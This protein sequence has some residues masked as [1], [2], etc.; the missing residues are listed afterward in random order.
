M[1]LV[2]RSELEIPRPQSEQSPNWETEPRSRNLGVWQSLSG[3]FIG[4]ESTAWQVLS[5]TNEVIRRAVQNAALLVQMENMGVSNKAERNHLLTLFSGFSS[6]DEAHR[7][8]AL[9]FGVQQVRHFTFFA[10]RES[11]RVD[12]SAYEEP[13]FEYP[14]QPKTRTDKPRLDRSG[15]PDKSPEKAVQRQKI[16]AEERALRQ[17][18]LSCIQDGMLDLAALERPVSPAV[19]CCLRWPTMDEFRALLDRFWVTR[20]KNKEL[21]FALKRIVPEYRRLINEQLGWNLIVNEAIVKLEKVPPRALPWMGIQSFQDPMDYCLLCAVLFFLAYLDDGA[22]FLLSSLT[23]AVETFLAEVR[24]VDW[25]QFLHRKCSNMP[26][27]L[28]W[29]WSVT[30]TARAL[31]GIG[32]RRCSIYMAEWMLLEKLEG[33]ILLAPAVGKLVGHY[34]ASFHNELSEGEEDGPLEDE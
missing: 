8:S 34:P 20:A 24:P 2:Q 28:A 26:R 14:L 10:I 22:P 6:V 17:E 19:R 29:Y 3:W 18:V 13:P 31:A 1:D 16:L 33:N 23:R 5:V 15:F 4:R 9:V 32:I 7:L 25:T 11:E 27:R 12:L 30:E 21:Y